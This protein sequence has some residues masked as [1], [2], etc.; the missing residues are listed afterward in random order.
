VSRQSDSDPFRDSYSGNPICV[1]APAVF[2]VRC[3]MTLRG[4]RPSPR[5]GQFL[6]TISPVLFGA[7]DRAAVEHGWQVPQQP[8]RRGGRKAPAHD[9][10]HA[11]AATGGCG[12]PAF[13]GPE[14]SS[15]RRRPRR[16]AASAGRHSRPRDQGRWVAPPALT[17]PHAVRNFCL[18]GSHVQSRQCITRYAGPETS[19][20]GRP[21]PDRRRH[22]P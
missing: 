1:F 10:F 16:Q 21:S 3:F 19:A 9:T 6:E 17:M 13:P 12:P 4:H 8:P 2:Q 14:S 15:R 5:L 18:E 22:A 20:R 7:D 11:A